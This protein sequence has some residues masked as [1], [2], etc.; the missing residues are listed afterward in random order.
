[1]LRKAL[2]ALLVLA[3]VGAAC[4]TDD[5]GGGTDGG[6]GDGGGGT[7]L[8]GYGADLSSDYAFYDVPIQEGAQFAVDEI[9]EAGG[10]L[11]NQLRLNTIDM[12]ND[13]AVGS[14]VVQQLIDEGAGYLIGTTGDGFLAQA[15]VACGAGV[16][17]S[18]GDGTAPTLVGDAGDCAF[19]LIMSDNI[20]GATLAEWARDE[21]HETAYVIG[22]SEIPYTANLPTYFSQ[23]FEA[24]GG[25]V[26]G[27]DQYQIGAGD[28]SAVVTKVRNASPTPEVIFT[29]M[30][31]P[32]TQ[33][34]LRQLRQAGVTTPV[35][36]TDGNLDPSLAEAGARALDGFTFT[37]SACP[38]EQDPT[39]Q[40]FMDAY[41]E[42]YGSEPS[43]VI[44]ALGYDE[45]Y[46]VK[47]ALEDANS[48][49]PGDLIEALQTVTHDGVTGTIEMDPETRRARK[50]V[51][52]VQMDGD[53][54]TC[55]G[56]PGVPSFVPEP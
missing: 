12:R 19:Q 55:L 37:A 50:S 13:V 42:R 39:I 47:A 28:Y 26:V 17:I 44:A 14:Q 38:A 20:Q 54:F 48:T 11:G 16:P 15:A 31:V 45:V 4:S 53:A 46:A 6:N 5:D 23:A 27:A 49:D 52:L 40:A 43:S 21:G 56:Q 3:L 32:D 1:M 10:V 18:T 22:S 29:P 2:P 25:T 33:V 7:F 34:F 8:I 51:A 9:N 24:A 35:V 41:A 30:F 36:S